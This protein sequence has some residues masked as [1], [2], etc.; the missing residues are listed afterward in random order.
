M[1]VV[2][3]FEDNIIDF[4]LF[5][6]K[7]GVELRCWMFNTFNNSKCNSH[8]VEIR[9]N[10]IVISVCIITDLL[11]VVLFS[12]LG[13]IHNL[14]ETLQMISSRW[15]LFPQWCDSPM[16]FISPSNDKG[17]GLFLCMRKYFSDSQKQSWGNLIETSR[18]Q[19]KSSAVAP[20]V[21]LLGPRPRRGNVCQG[22]KSWGES[23]QATAYRTHGPAGNTQTRTYTQMRSGWG[24]F[25]MGGRLISNLRISGCPAAVTSVYF[26]ICLTAGWP[27][28]QQI[29]ATGAERKTESCLDVTFPLAHICGSWLELI[30]KETDPG[31]SAETLQC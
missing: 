10:L 4:F 18:N 30:Q 6:L 21:W 27:S 7:K 3:K 14:A 26:S 29:T 19:W 11:S 9:F 25:E 5:L 28:S 1:E 12:Q 23:L 13:W 20:S 17:K 8:G 24:R 16:K 22:D 2:E 31:R 15:V